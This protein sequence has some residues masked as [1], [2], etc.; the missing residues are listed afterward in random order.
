MPQYPPS[1]KPHANHSDSVT[2]QNLPLL[3]KGE[4]RGLLCGYQENLKYLNMGKA[5]LFLV[6]SCNKEEEITA[7]VSY[8]KVLIQIRIY[9][10]VPCYLR[11]WKA[12]VTKAWS[13]QSGSISIT[14]KPVRTTNSGPDAG[15]LTE[16]KALG[17]RPGNPYFN[18]KQFWR[19]FKNWCYKELS[20][21]NI[22]SSEDN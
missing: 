1:N 15:I 12:A 13:L 18:S 21:Q 22:N 2:D 10:E 4:E 20:L 9:L 14:W 5:L 16:S 7:Y 17:V 19:M 11:T 3:D 8:L 6:W